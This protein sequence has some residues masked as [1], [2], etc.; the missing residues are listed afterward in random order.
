[1]MVLSLPEP[2]GDHPRSRGVYMCHLFPW[3]QADGSS[4]L[5]R[6][7]LIA[8]VPVEETTGI[9]PA[10]AGFTSN[11]ERTL[12]CSSDHP[13]SR[14]VYGQSAFLGWP[15]YGS[16][17]LA[18]GLRSGSRI[19]TRPPGIIPARAGFTLSSRRP[20]NQFRGSSPLARGLRSNRDPS[21]LEGRIIPA[22]AGFTVQLEAA[23][24][25]FEG[26]SP[27]ARGL[28]LLRR[29]S[30]SESGIIPAR[31]GF[32]PVAQNIIQHGGGSSPLARGLRPRA[33]SR[34]WTRGIIPA[35]AGFTVVGGDPHAVL[36]DHPRS[37]GVYDYWVYDQK[38][39]QGSSPLARGLRT[40]IPECGGSS[41]DHPRSRGVYLPVP[42]RGRRGP[43]SS[44]LARGLLLDQFLR[45]PRVGIIP[46]RA[47]FTIQPHASPGAWAGSSPLARGLRGVKRSPPVCA[48]IIPARAG[49]TC[50]GSPG[51]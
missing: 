46:A 9:I 12:P 25:I 17:P 5:A 42:V 8:G 50:A 34:T 36:R 4:P 33:S 49:F 45:R 48:G 32:T 1:M 21:G 47:G 38:M 30:L 35:R 6:G 15:R 28:R 19:S 11:S 41:R 37:R 20:S 29:G 24:Y 27:L 16:S 51:P 26:S 10:R 31:A 7:L 40:P 18:R 43:G 2:C 44:P 3:E 39:M 14:G 13:R 22:R 23:I